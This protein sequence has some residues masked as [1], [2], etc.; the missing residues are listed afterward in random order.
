M[1]TTP[2]AL[3]AINT[4]IKQGNGGSPEVFTTV[5]N[6]SSITG[7]GM[8]V[9]AVDVTSHSTSVPWREMFPTLLAAGELS[10]KLF[11]IP[12]DPGHQA[13][14]QSFMNRSVSDWQVVFPDP[15]RNYFQMVAFVSKFSLSMP[16]DNVVTA[17]VTFTA[18][19]EPFFSNLGD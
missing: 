18:T 1:S 6:V 9:N 2:I 19:G 15:N 11:F 5:A 14:L 12:G 17:D 8:S 7:L 16:V 10:F 4:L 3:A 13:L